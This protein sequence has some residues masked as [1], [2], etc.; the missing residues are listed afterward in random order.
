[1]GCHCTKCLRKVCKTSWWNK[2]DCCVSVS[3]KQFL[4]GAQPPTL[5]GRGKLHPYSPHHR[6]LCVSKISNKSQAFETKYYGHPVIHVDY[7]KYLAGRTIY[8]SRW[9]FRMIT[10][11]CK[12]NTKW[13]M[14]RQLSNFFP[15]SRVACFYR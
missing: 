8:P 5:F 13:S 3:A 11:M 6:P 15:I 7:Q 10:T 2:I 12:I 9:V 14:G 1:M 4:W